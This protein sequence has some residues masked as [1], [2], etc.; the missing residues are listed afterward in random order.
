MKT[1]FVDVGGSKRARIQWQRW[2]QKVT[3]LMF[4]VSLS[5]FDEVMFEMRQSEE[6]RIQSIYLSQL[7]IV[8]SLKEQESSSC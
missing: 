2:W 3:H 8:P 5:D 4:V 1:E 7:Q 6:Q